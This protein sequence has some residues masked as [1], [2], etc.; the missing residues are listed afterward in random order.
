MLGECQKNMRLHWK[1]IVHIFITICLIV[2]LI[3][4]YLPTNQ[5]IINH[6]VCGYYAIKN[7]ITC[8]CTPLVATGNVVT[9]I[10]YPNNSYY[11]SFPISSS[12]DSD[13]SLNVSI[14]NN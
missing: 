9:T 3:W 11:K 5:L 2:F 13:W 6:D 14:R 1:R 7:N 10:F 4:Y 8:S 12:I